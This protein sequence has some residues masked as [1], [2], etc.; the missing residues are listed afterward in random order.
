VLIVHGLAEHGGR[1]ERTA[2][3]MADA[4]LAV[5][6]VDLRGAGGSA[7]RRA[8]VERFSDYLDDVEWRLAVVREA[9]AGRPVTLL[10]HSLGGLVCL[11]YVTSGRPLPDLLILSSPAVASTIPPWKQALAR[12]FDSVAPTARVPNG[13]SGDQLSSDPAVGVA[14]FA[15]PLVETSSTFRLGAD[16]FRAQDRVRATSGRLSIPTFVTH[17]GADPIVPVASSEYLAALPG[18]TRT[19][20]PGLRHETLNEPEGPAIVADMIAWLRTQLADAGR[21]SE[22]GSTTA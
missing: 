11:D 2:G 4:G 8:H 13:V 12:T 22:G 10:G 6:A 9:A 14:Y 20:Y 19:V 18:V 7:G 3:L 17:G 21:P 15:D 5:E 1:Y 16:S